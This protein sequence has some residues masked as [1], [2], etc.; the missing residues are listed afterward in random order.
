MQ[1]ER[2]TAERDHLPLPGRSPPT[3]LTPPWVQ[4]PQQDCTPLTAWL[5]FVGRWVPASVQQIIQCLPMMKHVGS[6]QLSCNWHGS[7]VCLPSHWDFEKKQQPFPQWVLPQAHV[8]H[9]YGS[10][11]HTQS[12]TF[13]TSSA[14]FLLG[15]QAPTQHLCIFQGGLRNLILEHF[16]LGWLGFFHFS[17]SCLEFLCRSEDLGDFILLNTSAFSQ[18]EVLK[19]L[20]TMSHLVTERVFWSE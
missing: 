19:I 10:W 11:K 12:S 15:V 2:S 18:T 6:A 7:L 8:A 4:G 16:H 20:F 9:S 1:E 5:L 13:S 3:S 14:A 17:F